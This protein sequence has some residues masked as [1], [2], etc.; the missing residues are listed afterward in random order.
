M[1]LSVNAE[2]SSEMAR[3]EWLATLHRVTHLDAEVGHKS[4][5]YQNTTLTAILRSFFEDVYFPQLKSL[6]NLDS[7]EA[8]RDSF[9]AQLL[10]S[11]QMGAAYP[12]P[13][14]YVFASAESMKGLEEYM[15]ELLFDWLTA[16]V[17]QSNR[18]YDPKV[19]ELWTTWDHPQLKLLTTE[20]TGQYMSGFNNWFD[21]LKKLYPTY[22]EVNAP[23]DNQSSVREQLFWAWIYLCPSPQQQCLAHALWHRMGCMDRDTVRQRAE[24]AVHSLSSAL[25]RLSLPGDEEE[26]QIKRE[27]LRQAQE[28]LE[29][30]DTSLDL[31]GSKLLTE[32][33]TSAAT[34]LPTKMHSSA[35]GSQLTAILE[36]AIRIVEEEKSGGRSI[37]LASNCRTCTSRDDTKL[38]PVTSTQ[39]SSL[40]EFLQDAVEVAN[41]RY[42]SAA[43]TVAAPARGKVSG[44]SAASIKNV[45]FASQAS[46]LTAEMIAHNREVFDEVMRPQLEEHGRRAAKAAEAALE[47]PSATTAR[48][49]AVSRRR[50]TSAGRPPPPVPTTAYSSNRLQASLATH[51]GPYAGHD[52]PSSTREHV[53]KILTSLPGQLPFM[54]SV[55]DQLRSVLS[56]TS[57][58][59]IEFGA[60][61][62]LIV[63]IPVPATLKKILV[64]SGR[65]FG[66]LILS[67]WQSLGTRTVLQPPDRI[68]VRWTVRTDEEKKAPSGATTRPAVQPAA[69]VTR[70]MATSASLAALLGRKPSAP[71]VGGK[72]GGRRVHHFGSNGHSSSTKK[73]CSHCGHANCQC[74]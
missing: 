4:R 2:R 61:K 29:S 16:A 39:G 28:I 49:A 19:A 73:C 72:A 21:E 52:D 10:K 66:D 14:E 74:T 41:S 20:Q 51:G 6:E 53:I 38:Q 22:V 42:P 55:M 70:P 9:L 50:R 8:K 33:K 68:E 5:V 71:R 26:I 7:Y 18:I 48:S 56:D 36:D 43:S 59:K 17:T 31:L 44:G 46:G 32:H 47:S 34:P 57:G 45:R 35:G 3:Q 60:D 13:V 65:N 23:R 12:S 11:N 25:E 63:T 54:Y 15:P 24:D 27:A 69:A 58:I 62:K 64:L 40:V 67:K 30:D 37:R 1:H